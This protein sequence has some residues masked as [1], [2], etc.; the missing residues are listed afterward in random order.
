M[1]PGTTIERY[2]TRE[3]KLG[4]STPKVISVE[5]CPGDDREVIHA[6][7]AWQSRHEY[8]DSLI[9]NLDP[10]PIKVKITVRVISIYDVC[11]SP[12]NQRAAKGYFKILA[13]DNT[14]CILV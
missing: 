7:D 11:T 5:G 12:Q 4:C 6:V 13:K 8:K 2:F 9:G 10:G 3:R 1:G 14:G